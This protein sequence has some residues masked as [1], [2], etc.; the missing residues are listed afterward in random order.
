MHA[1]DHGPG[2]RGIAQKGAGFEQHLSIAER[3]GGVRQL[4]V[5]LLQSRDKIGG[6]KTP[7]GQGG[8]I[9]LDPHGAT[10]PADEGGLGDLRDGFNRVIQLRGEPAQGQVIVGDTVEGEG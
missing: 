8:G 7:G 4:A 2:I 1:D 10:D 9:E 5:G 3:P 6:S